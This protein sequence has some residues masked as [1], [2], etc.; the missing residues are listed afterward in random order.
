MATRRS[1]RGSFFLTY[2]FLLALIGIIILVSIAAPRFFTLTNAI[3]ILHAAAP[4]MILATGIA[5]VLMTGKIDISV[6]SIAFLS[7]GVG[8]E[9]MLH[10]HV[11][12]VAAVPFVFFI[13][14][15]LGAFNGFIVVVL[16]VNPLITTLG[17]LFMFRGLALQI[18]N[19]LT[20]SIPENLSNF[21]SLRLG[22]IFIDIFIA[23]AFVALY[24]LIH[25]RSVFGRQV[26]AI[27]NGTEVAQKLGV[28]VDR[29]VFFTFVLSGFMASIGGAFSMF[30]IGSISASLGQGYEFTA[31][32][33]LVIGG[34]SLFGGEGTIVPGILLGAL[35]LTIIQSGLNFIGASV[36]A[37]PL[38]RGAIIFFATYADSL[39]N[40]LQRPARLLTEEEGDATAV[41]P[42]LGGGSNRV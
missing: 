20:I 12:S 2:G 14:A 23:A 1:R 11:N 7:A 36:F 35:T 4:T 41:Q 10:G 26:M 32:A 40:R 30:Q 5:F 22:P 38:V 17:T 34:V 3:F 9:L 42:E 27:G 8:I 19:S 28:P 18:T 25:T 37:Y 16:R 24:H 15:L 21:G 6:G 13:G 39:K 29:T 31:I 33:L